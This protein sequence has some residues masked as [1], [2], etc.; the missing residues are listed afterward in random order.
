MMKMV[1][2][3]CRGPLVDI[4]FQAHVDPYCPK[5]CR[6]GSIVTK[7]KGER[8][9]M[10]QANGWAELWYC[11]DPADYSANLFINAQQVPVPDDGSDFYLYDWQFDPSLKPYRVDIR[12][13]V[14]SR[15]VPLPNGRSVAKVFVKPRTTLFVGG[16]Q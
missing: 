5:D 10:R 11:F 9:P 15:A 14:T 8:P 12:G 3:H 1:C 6:P 16:I 7:A 13:I 4:L 2:P